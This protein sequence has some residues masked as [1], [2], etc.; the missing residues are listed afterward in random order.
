MDCLKSTISHFESKDGCVDLVKFLNCS[1]TFELNTLKKIENGERSL[2]VYHFMSSSPTQL[3][4]SSVGNPASVYASRLG[5]QSRTFHKHGGEFSVCF[6]SDGSAIEE[7]TLF[8]GKSGAP[9]VANAFSE[10]LRR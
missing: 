2:A 8:R 10:W 7:W 4:T 6:F 3:D 9:E 5:A 1:A